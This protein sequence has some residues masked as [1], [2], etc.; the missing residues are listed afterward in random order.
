MR[1]MIR[2]AVLLQVVAGLALAGAWLYTCESYRERDP[3][4]LAVLV[5]G[6][7]TLLAAAWE[8]VIERDER[9][10]HR[11]LWLAGA[12]FG[13]DMLLD[14]GSPYPA[15]FGVLG[16]E[17]LKT[18]ALF[19]GWLVAAGLPASR[20][21]RRVAIL[22]A[23]ASLVLSLAVPVTMAY[24]AL[25]GSRDDTAPADAALVLGYALAAD[26]TAQPQLVGRMAHASD[27]VK[28]GVVP[29]LVLSG[30]AAK[31]GHT[32]ASVMRDLARA[33]GVP[34]TA[35]VL[36]E[37]ARSTI[38]NFACSRPI[39]EHAHAARVLLVTE[40]WHMTR[41]QLLARRHGITARQSPASSAIWTS[42][43]HATY[44]LFRD[45]VAFLHELARDPFAEPGT[46]NARVCEGCRTF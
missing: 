5:L 16:W 39:L 22:L 18:A 20:W 9:R 24:L 33:A 19:A 44:W 26:G 45:A 3:F 27:L 23:A 21:W 15:R 34:D 7:G 40:P 42:P 25:D 30:G 41:A 37:A 12:L 32:E 29:R 14:A 43:R 8:T 36:D 4:V 17:A 2:R 6:P 31:N 28:R 38:E 11:V 10:W 35:I 1:R 13:I 46:C